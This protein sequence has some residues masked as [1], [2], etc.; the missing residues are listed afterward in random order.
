[1]EGKRIIDVIIMILLNI[2]IRESIPD[3][4]VKNSEFP[5]LKFRHRD[6]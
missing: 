2:L 4:L 3:Q 1:M 6:F 5:S